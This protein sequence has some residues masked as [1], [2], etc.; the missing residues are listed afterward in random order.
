[1]RLIRGNLEN[2]NVSRGQIADSPEESAPLELEPLESAVAQF[3]I[4]R[5]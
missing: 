5:H 2:Q 3:V 4:A 1:V